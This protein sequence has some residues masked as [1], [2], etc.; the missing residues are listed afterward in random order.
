MENLPAYINVIFILTTLLT[1]LFIYKASNNS[2][3]TLVIIWAWLLLQAAIASTGFYTITNSI[4]P[5]LL[6]L[7]MPPLIVII[8]MFATRTGRNFINGLDVKTLTLLHIV[9]IPVEFVLICLFINKTVPKIMT[10]EGMNFDILS[11]LTAPLMW[12]LGFVKKKLNDN[13]VL[14]WNIL[15]VILLLNIVIIAILSAPLNFQQFAFEQPNIAILY[16]PFI[17]LPCFIVP[18]VLF[19]HL[20]AIS[21]LLRYKEKSRLMIS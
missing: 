6:F 15:C 12:Y 16:F 13:I 11:G 14:S 19:S 17:W 8:F 9:R 10:F 18:V 2:K 3:K 5:R 4:P 20:V 1:S 7:L 21:R